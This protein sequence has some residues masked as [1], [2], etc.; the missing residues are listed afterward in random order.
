VMIGAHGVNDGVLAELEV[1][2]HAHELIKIRLPQVSHDERDDMIQ[3]LSH[4]SHADVVGRIGR[5]LILY[6]PRPAAAL[7]R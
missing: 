6:R 5:I 1:A 2:I 7:K 3:T 4:A